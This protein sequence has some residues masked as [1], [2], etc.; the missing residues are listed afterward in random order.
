[1]IVIQRHGLWDTTVDYTVGS[2]DAALGWSDI[3]TIFAAV[4]DRIACQGAVRWE[5]EVHPIPVAVKVVRKQ[6]GVLWILNIDSIISAVCDIILWNVAV[7]WVL[8]VNAMISDTVDGAVYNAYVVGW[9]CMDAMLIIASR[10]AEISERVVERWLKMHSIVTG[11]WVCPPCDADIIQCVVLWVLNIH[12]M[13][14]TTFLFDDVV[15]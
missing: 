6:G 11:G 15:W 13:I 12:T 14:V 2:E 7:I 1:M 9:I 5:F 8:Y 3:N 10:N 4:C